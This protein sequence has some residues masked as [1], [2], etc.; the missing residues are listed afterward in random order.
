[1]I[2]YEL[3]FS[4]LLFISITLFSMLIA[5][6]FW[7]SKDGRLRVLII[8]LFIAKV[9]V[10]GGGGIYYYLRAIGY[11]PYLSLWWILALN[12]PMC[13]V[14]FRLYKFIRQKK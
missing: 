3:L 5:Y 12:A 14:M 6:E 2:K 1:M 7:K 4:E 11:L 13:W 9:W 8:E 10:Y